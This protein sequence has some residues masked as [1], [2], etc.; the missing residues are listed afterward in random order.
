MGGWCGFVLVGC[1]RCG[2]VAMGACGSV[3]L[4]C[5]VGHGWHPMSCESPVTCSMLFFL[6]LVSVCVCV[7]VCFVMFVCQGTSCPSGKYGG[8]NSYYGAASQA[9]ATCLVSL[10]SLCCSACTSV[11]VW[12]LITCDMCVH[13]WSHVHVGARVCLLWAGRMFGSFCGG[14]ATSCR[15][16]ASGYL[17]MCRPS[18]VWFVSFF[19]FL[20]CFFC[21]FRVPVVIG[22]GF[23]CACCVV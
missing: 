8:P 18:R 11:V 13:P 12:V 20:F 9:D 2:P 6:T 4:R 16:S 10:I 1:M 5:C 14:R 19:F 21:C 22:F 15:A 3:P 7:C 17:L 23:V